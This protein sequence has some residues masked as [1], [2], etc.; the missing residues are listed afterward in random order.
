MEHMHMQLA[1]IT[2]SIIYLISSVLNKSFKIPLPHSLII[3]SYLTYQ[4]FPEFLNINASEHFD[5]IIFFLIPII[6]MYDAMHL[7]WKDIKIYKYSISYLAVVSVSISILLG[8]LLYKFEIFGVGLSIGMYV[9]LFSINMA[10]DAISVNNIFSQFKGI[11]HNIKVLVEGESLGNDATAMIAFYFIGLPWIINGSFDLTTIP[12]IMFKVYGLSTVIGLSIGILGYQL[13]K[14]FNL[15]K[16]ELLIV[17]V[18]SYFSFS[19]GEIAHVS[20]IFSIIVAII[21]LTTLIQNSISEENKNIVISP[22]EKKNLFKFL[23][24]EVSTKT[25]QNEINNTLDIFSTFAVILV[26]VVMANTIDI[27]NLIYYW[28]EILI[29]FLATTFIRMI[30]MAKFVFIGKSTKAIDY[31][32]ING[33]VILTLAGIKGSL[34]IIMLHALPKDF[35]FYTLFESVTIGVILLSTFIYGFTLLFYMLNQEKKRG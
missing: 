30:V 5:S 2:M 14:N 34:S 17:L 15:L 31:V 19:L 4:T 21:T 27:N 8:A 7:K 23:K 32:G 29:M 35:E 18:V 16:E 20:G 9:A 22:K 3:L 25:K 33:W 12:L 1:F 28:K 26:Y 24:K 6:L 11:P 13:M 10:T